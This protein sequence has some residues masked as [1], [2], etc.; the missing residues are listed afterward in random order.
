V[1]ILLGLLLLTAG[2]LK[3]Y[4]RLTS[5]PDSAG[6]F[7]GA[8]WLQL[9]WVELELGLGVWL[10]SGYRQRTARWAALVCFAMFAAVNAYQVWRGAPS[11]GCFG[12]LYIPPLASLALDGCCLAGLALIRPASEV[13]IRRSTPYLPASRLNR[14]TCA[15]ACMGCGVLVAIKL[16]ATP[17]LQGDVKIEPAYHDFG[18]SEQ[19]QVLSHTFTLT[20][21]ADRPVEVVRASSTCGCVAAEGAVGRWV[22]PGETL[23][24]PVSLKTVNYDGVRDGQFTLFYRAA[25]DRRLGW[26]AAG[27]RTTVNTDY[28]VRP[29]HI[30]FGRVDYT[31][32]RARQVRLRPLNGRAVR[33]LRAE[34]DH[35][36]LTAKAAGVDANGDWLIDVEFCAADFWEAGRLVSRIQIVTD[37]ARNPQMAV[38][39]EATVDPPVTV[40]PRSAVI[41]Q[42]THG[43]VEKQFVVRHTR[44]VTIRP[45]A[46][47]PSFGV[48]VTPI[49]SGMMRINVSVPECD[50]PQPLK[51]ELV[52]EVDEGAGAGGTPPRTFALAIHRHVP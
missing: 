16:V 4:E 3:G 45:K 25:G 32:P 17:P 42:Y 19:H 51:A 34:S 49:D 11:C 14:F 21:S 5:P 52:F 2:A 38:E 33:V 31:R 46:V 47:P 40:Q 15:A 18:P 13:P 7:W 35:A 41:S 24:F 9:L 36:A 12:A 8:R 43:V 28:L 22:A 29:T 23:A 37:S 44:P 6:A 27:V 48:A 1:R 20:N 30:D 10:L 50:G 39:V 26:A